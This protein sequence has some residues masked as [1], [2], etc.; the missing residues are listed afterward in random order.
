MTTNEEVQSGDI[1]PI[2]GTIDHDFQGNKDGI[3][4]FFPDS[5][6]YKSSFSRT[7][8]KQYSD[9]DQTDAESAIE[10]SIPRSLT[11]IEDFPNKS[12]TSSRSSV[13]TIYLGYQRKKSVSVKL[14]RIEHNDTHPKKVVRF[15]DDFGLDLSQIK[16]F[17]DDLPSIP[18]PTFKNLHISEPMRIITYME[19]QFENPIHTQSFIDRVSKHKIV[20][21]QASKSIREYK[22]LK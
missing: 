14:T 4:T 22:F 20:L 10:K 5:V 3:N 6:S 21:E 19:P 1:Y 15:A 16:M 18:S 11:Q 17:T 12:L 9:E 8:Q 7:I 2:N 13:P